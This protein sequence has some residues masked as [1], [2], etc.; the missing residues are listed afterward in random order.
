[1]FIW[2]DQIREIRRY[3]DLKLFERYISEENYDPNPSYIFPYEYLKTLDIHHLDIILKHRGLDIIRESKDDKIDKILNYHISNLSEYCSDEYSH[4]IHIHTTETTVTEYL[5]DIILPIDNGSDQLKKLIC[6]FDKTPPRFYRH[7]VCISELDEAIRDAP[8]TLNEDTYLYRGVSEPS[9]VYIQRCIDANEIV[10]KECM[11]NNRN[12]FKHTLTTL[13]YSST[14]KEIAI[15]KSYVKN[16]CCVL[17]F[18]VPNN[19]DYLDTT[20]LSEEDGYSDSDLVEVLLQRNLVY[21][22]FKY[23]EIVNGKIIIDCKILKVDVAQIDFDKD[24]V[25]LEDLD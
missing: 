18:K 23:N 14:S 24:A 25:Y 17:R 22:N 21:L 12:F 19:V 9:L 7:L 4:I 2:S 1:M 8:K 11:S 5:K 16:N 6:G 20:I 15:A 3:F 13:H 10:K